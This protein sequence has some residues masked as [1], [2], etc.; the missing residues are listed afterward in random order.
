MQKITHSAN[1]K[2]NTICDLFNWGG[3]GALD[4]AHLALELEGALDEGQHDGACTSARD[5]DGA[6]IEQ[7]TPQALL[8]QD[9]LD[10]ADDNLVGMAMNPAMAM[11]KPLVAHENRCREVADKATQMQISDFA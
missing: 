4:S 2:V 1:Q 7:P 9:A 6:I 3:A 11:K 8:D 5:L 10:L